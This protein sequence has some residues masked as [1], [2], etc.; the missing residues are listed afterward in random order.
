MESVIIS[1]K[2]QIQEK[3]TQLFCE[4]GYAATSMRDLAQELDI[5]AASL[6]SH[7]KSKE[8]ILRKICFKIASL[9][10]EAFQK[11]EHQ[12]HDL[13]AEEYLKLAIIEHV[14]VIINDVA[15]SA[16][17]LN[18]WRHISEP[19]LTEFITL[20][21]QY[22]QKFL[23]IL[24]KGTIKKEFTGIDI[25]LATQFLLSSI[26]WTYSWYKPSGRMSPDEIGNIL[27]SFVINGLIN[28][29]VVN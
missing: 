2:I 5:E 27:A 21:K 9:F 13:S 22:E 28:K 11:I 15:A 23:D 14:K 8:E 12:S 10:F 24:N 18:E 6:Y 17:F 25:K 16:V 7:I 4:K 1:R 29:D 3:A 20:R 19:Y 26:N